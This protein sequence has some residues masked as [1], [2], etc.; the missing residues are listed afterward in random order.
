MGAT[1]AS[2]PTEIWQRVRRTRPQQGR[3]SEKTAYFT[4]D[5]SL[6]YLYIRSSDLSREFP[7]REIPGKSLKFD[8]RE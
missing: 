5:V 7:D 3:R 2:A 1:G 4:S 6:I 8:S